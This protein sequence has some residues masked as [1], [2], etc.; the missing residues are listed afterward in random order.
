MATLNLTPYIPTPASLGDA[1][2]FASAYAAIMA[3]VNGIDNNNFGAGKIFDP[4]KLMQD[5]ATAGQALI[6]SAAANSGT[7]GWVPGSASSIDGWSDLSSYGTMAYVSNDNTVATGV[8]NIPADV[9]LVVQPGH[10][11]KLTQSATVKYFIVTAVGAYS[12]GNTPVTLY[13]GTD[14]TLANAAITF[15]AYSNV[16]TPFGFNTLPTKWAQTLSDVTQRTQSSPVSSTWYNPGSL[17][18]AVPIGAW[19]LSYQCCMEVT[20]AAGTGDQFEAIQATLSTANNSSSD[21]DFNARGGIEASVSVAADMS[22]EQPVTM[23][24]TVLVAAKTSYF[25]NLRCQTNAPNSIAFR[26]DAMTAIVIA[27]SA[28]L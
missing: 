16:Q 10:R 8:V 13:G 18:L 7:G 28:Y 15:P 25:L 21:S 17:T 12:G 20:G 23:R 1:G 2:Q 27:E 11:I 4:L 26:N 22:L 9:T 3:A 14:Y 19:R 5:G 24:K 6:W